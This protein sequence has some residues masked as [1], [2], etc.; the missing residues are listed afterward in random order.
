MLKRTKII[1]TTL[2]LV[3]LV[4]MASPALA[5]GTSPA[6]RADSSD[7]ACWALLAPEGEKSSATKEETFCVNG[8][9]EDLLLALKTER[10][11]IVAESTAEG[12]AEVAAAQR[13][14]RANGVV[15]PL[16][17]WVLARFW[18]DATYSGSSYLFT[19]TV[20]SGCSSHAFYANL[21]DYTY[22]GLTTL[23]NDTSSV[24]SA[25]PCRTWLYV[26]ANQSGS[27]YGPIAGSDPYVGWMNDQATSAAWGA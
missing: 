17:T 3:A 22:G 19:T 16:A 5:A 15:T 23:D 24:Q 18:R 26:D 25:A 6:S 2:T 7:K 1:A 9:E 8:S 10:N 21:Y 12:R 27:V 20:G 4:S 13:E 11:I 14:A